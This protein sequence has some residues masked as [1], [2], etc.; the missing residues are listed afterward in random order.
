MVIQKLFE[1]QTAILAEKFD[2]PHLKMQS[3]GRVG[4]DANNITIY[5]N[6]DSE[7][8]SVNLTA[9]LGRFIPG[10]DSDKCFTMLRLNHLF[11]HP[12]RY[13]FCMDKDDCIILKT[14]IPE[15]AWSQP[16]GLEQF[17]SSLLT[18]LTEFKDKFGS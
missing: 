12:K 11:F 1:Q 14:R 17:I 5:L 3:G 4:F 13:A 9:N 8:A 6:V 18:E 10:S 15:S 16:D 7:Q 2:C